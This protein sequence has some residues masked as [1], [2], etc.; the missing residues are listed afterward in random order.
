MKKVYLSAYCRCNLGDDLFVITLLRRYPN[1]QF[2]LFAD[3][4][5]CDAFSEESNLRIVS[6]L[7]YRLYEILNRFRLT[8]MNRVHHFYSKCYDVTVKIGGSIF[9]EP[10]NWKI[11]SI[12][13]MFDYY[14]GA[15][16]GPYKSN[17]YLE[18]IKKRI[19]SAKDCC[20]RDSYSYGIFNAFSNVRIA[21]DVLF[22]YAY[23]PFQK[24]SSGLG[25]SVISLENRH[26]LFS[27][28]E[29]YYR[30]IA[31]LCDRCV[32]QGIPVKL[33][34]FCKAEGDSEA[35][36]NILSYVSQTTRVQVCAYEGNVDEFLDEL[37]SCQYILATR[38]HA[39]ILGWCMG[40]RVLPIIYSGKQTQ[41]IEDI[42]YEGVCWDLLNGMEYSAENLLNDCLTS[43]VM[44]VSGLSL[45]SIDQ[46]NDLDKCLAKD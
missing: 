36:S 42:G 24:E 27:Q 6:P 12:Q 40:K 29:S 38:F 11:S 5:Q 31:D 2:F 44:D 14:I 9:I 41:V 25:I 30:T 43:K 39:M 34:S 22:G 33:F 23:Y 10:P 26:E 32:E 45:D 35:L 18:N 4:K 8:D 46:F 21:P 13:P 16:F 20:F 28:S 19:Q 15:N 7:K 37:N 17:E 1:V 3:R